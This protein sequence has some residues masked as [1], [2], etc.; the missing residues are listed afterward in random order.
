MRV[1]IDMLTRQRVDGEEEL[2][3]HQAE[4]DL[5]GEAGSYMLLYQEQLPDSGAAVQNSIEVTAEGVR[6][7]KQ[8][9]VCTEICY[10]KGLEHVCAYQTPYGLMEMG[11]L[12]RGMELREEGEGIRLRLVYDLRSGGAHIA[13]CELEITAVPCV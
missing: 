4:G 1:M 8:G 9:A 3:R 12:T 10:R 5:Q 7:Q 13:D 6:V 11:F 2:L